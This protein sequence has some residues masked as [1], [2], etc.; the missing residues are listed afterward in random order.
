MLTKNIIPPRLTI[1]SAIVARKMF[2]KFLI[3]LFREKKVDDKGYNRRISAEN[4][5]ISKLPPS[6]PDIKSCPKKIKAMVISMEI[7]YSAKKTFL[8]I[9]IEFVW[10]EK[11]ISSSPKRFDPKSFTKPI[12]K[13]VA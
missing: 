5:R 4:K 3:P 10:A 8:K 12:A 7:A 9:L 13:A 6:I 11:C 2:L 1:F